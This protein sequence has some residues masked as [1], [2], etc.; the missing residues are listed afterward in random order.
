MEEYSDRRSRTEIAFHRRGSRFSYRNGSPEEMTNHNS[1]GLGSS[2]RLNPSLLAGVTDN[3]ERP[4]YLHDSFKS[5]SSNVGPTSSSKFPPRKFEEKR[6]QPLLTGVD[7]GESG[8]RKVEPSKQ[9]E[10]S[11]KIIVDDESS[12]TLLIESKGFTT[13]QDRLLT[14]GQE[15]S[16]FAGPSGVSANRAESLVRTASLSSRTHRQK[17]KEVNLGTPGACSSS[18]TNRFTMPR[19]STTGVRPAYGHVSGVQRRGLKNLGCNPV[20]DVQTSGCS[21]DSVYSR[22]FEFMRKKASDLESSSRSRSFSGPSNS[23]HSF[24][25]YICDAGPR[26]RLNGSLLSQH[27]ESSSRSRSF[28][29]PS[30][31]DH[32]SPT[33]I[34]DTGPIRLNETL[35]SQHPESSS[36][37]RRFSGPSNSDHSSPTYIRDTGPR[38]RL[39]ETLLSQQ[40]VR[41]SSRNQQESAVSVRT[42]RPSHAT[43][44]R[45]T[46]ERA[47]GML[48]LHESS[49]R[50]GQSAQEHLSLEEVSAGS[51]VRPFFAELPHDIY[52]FSRHQSS[53][54]RAE[55][56]RR[57]S[58]FEESPPQMFHGLMGERDGHRHITMGEIAE[59]LTNLFLGA[60][61]SHDRHRDMRMDIDSMSYEEL[62][63]LLEERIGYVSTALSD[64]QFAKC[65]RRSI[66]CPVATGVNKSVIDD[67]KCSIC[68]E[69]YKE[70][71]EIGQLPCEHGYHV[72][73]IGQWLRLKNW[74]PVC[75]ASAVPS[76]D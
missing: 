16:Y 13:E 11:K 39:N 15:G 17:E 22:R 66:Y 7:I 27:P 29:G 58:H 61:A 3:Q 24:P 72:C 56:G 21:S 4:R 67:I 60:F 12:D 5:S 76:M 55:R 73:C 34:R 47:D 40:I 65:L 41:S 43:T 71:E 62:L 69:E 51:S 10:G 31:S 49:T 28:S 42:R 25:T 46:D 23:D 32:S 35:L 38:I 54:T 2:I 30:N 20:P 1:D 57:N 59:E 70:G 26:I 52:S 45:A 44:L 19:N 64:E 63:A 75:K 14:P 50:N 36:R 9:L 33:Y 18:L 74:C 6:R 37:S 48:S 68:Q 53:N 8:R